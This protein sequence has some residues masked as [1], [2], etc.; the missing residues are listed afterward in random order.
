MRFFELYPNAF[1]T[2]E[3]QFD[4]IIRVIADHVLFAHNFPRDTRVAAHVIANHE[5]GGRYTLA[6]KRL[7]DRR[8]RVFVWSVVE[9]EI[10]RT[11][12]WTAF[13]RGAED[14]IK[15]HHRV[16]RRY[17]SRTRC[18]TSGQRSCHASSATSG[19]AM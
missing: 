7:Q 10:D 15:T 3:E 11:R 16:T 6:C 12:A 4:V 2:C 9:C 18:A 13:D 5:E 8:R 19:V 1:G 17:T 14:Q